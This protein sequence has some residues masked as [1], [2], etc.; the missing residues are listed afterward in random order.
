MKY[1]F[2]FLMG[3]LTW[4]FGLGVFFSVILCI[5]QFAGLSFVSGV[6]YW[7]PLQFF[8][9]WMISALGTIATVVS[10]R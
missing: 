2:L 4:V 5:L 6:S 3:V 8:G 7:L 10:V 1:F 9:A